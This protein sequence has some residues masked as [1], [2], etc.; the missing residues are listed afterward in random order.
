LHGVYDKPSWMRMTKP[1]FMAEGKVLSRDRKA[2]ARLRRALKIHGSD[3]FGRTAPIDCARFPYLSQVL[4][5]ALKKLAARGTK[6][7]LLFPPY[8]AISYY[9]WIERRFSND[10]F[11]PGP[12]YPQIMGFK[13]CVLAVAK[14]FGEDV[15]VHAVDNDPAITGSLANYMDPLHM[16]APAAYQRVIDHVAKGDSL[17]TEENFPAYRQSLENSIRRAGRLLPP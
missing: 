7:D 15:R 8:P 17:L 9:D 4:T 16:I 10:P 2:I 12:V 11:P 6:V 1:S 14:P 3:V 5:P 13:T